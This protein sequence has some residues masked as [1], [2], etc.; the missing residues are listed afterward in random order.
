MKNIKLSD[1]LKAALI[2]AVRTFAQTAAATLGVAALLSE[3][4]WA[5]VL[6]ASLLS[7][8]LSVL[9]SIGGIPE[10]GEGAAKGISEP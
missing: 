5:E 1:W 4:S 3:V 9:M 7:A 6:S 10:A 8:I 2:R